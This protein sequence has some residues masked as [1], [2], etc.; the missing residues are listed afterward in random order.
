[1]LG[2][3]KCM[4]NFDKTYISVELFCT[5]VHI[6]EC[7]FLHI[8]CKQYCQSLWCCQLVRWKILCPFNFILL[9]SVICEVEHIFIFF[10]FFCE[11]P[12]LALCPFL[13]GFWKF[14]YQFLILFLKDIK[15]IG[16]FFW[17][18]LIC[19]IRHHSFYPCNNSS[20]SVLF[21]PPF[22]WWR[23]LSKGR[24]SNLPKVTRCVEGRVGTRC[25]CLCLSF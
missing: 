6:W 8:F 21:H 17:F 11:L 23:N 15:E 19:L 2:T 4:C 13:L 1:M 18:F 5:P 12:D 20:L 25:L 3:D 22:N 24:L 9:F 16:P 7:L 10:S 14:S